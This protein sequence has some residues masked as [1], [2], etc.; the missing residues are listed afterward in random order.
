ML[1]FI[2]ESWQWRTVPFIFSDGL[3]AEVRICVLRPMHWTGILVV[4]ID[5]SQKKIYIIC[6]IISTVVV[7]LLKTITQSYCTDQACLLLHFPKK[8]N[9]R[10]KSLFHGTHKRKTKGISILMWFLS[11]LSNKMV[12]N[13]KIQSNNYQYRIF[14]FM[15][16]DLT[17][18]VKTPRKDIN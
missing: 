12:R 6:L 4:K 8:I 16:V 11:F 15:Y 2:F 18:F 14:F 3:K 5:K 9:R 13:L 10:K 1:S 17:V 7:A